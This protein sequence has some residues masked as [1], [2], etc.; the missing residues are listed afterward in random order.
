MPPTVEN[1]EDFLSCI[2][3]MPRNVVN[4]GAIMVSCVTSSLYVARGSYKKS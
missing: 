4:K 3:K 1:Y 2:V